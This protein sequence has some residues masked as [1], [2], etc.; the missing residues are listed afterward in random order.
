[1]EVFKVAKRGRKAY[2][3][4]KG[5]IFF[6]CTK[7]LSVKPEGD[8]HNM[9]AGFMGKMANCVV[10][11]REACREH[12]SKHR[13]ELNEKQ[14]NY[15]HDNK[16]AERERSRKWNYENS[17]YKAQKDKE[18]RE[19][20]PEKVY[21]NRKR[22]AEDNKEK[23]LEQGR[24]WRTKNKDRARIHKRKWVINNREKLVLK[25]LR[26][27]T[28]KK[29]LPFDFDVKKREELLEIYNFSC[30]FTG[31]ENFHLDH[32]IPLTIGHGGSVFKNMIPLRADLNL[33]KKNHNIFE[34]VKTRSDI[35]LNRFNT[36]MGEIAERNN[37]SLDQYREYVY[38]CFEN[39]FAIVLDI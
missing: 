24:N 18:W 34:W 25:E 12:H 14:K 11:H 5:N 15:Y 9:S 32:V 17:E 20:N 29:A 4:N 31:S 38:D 6:D 2:K 36:V 23:H 10:C 22:W 28:I 27:R 7:C 21:E 26:R 3:D 33:S 30:A 8:F 37:M 16:E 1:M 35:D 39:P 13:E 19:N